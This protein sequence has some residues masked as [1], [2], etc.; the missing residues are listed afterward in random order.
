MSVFLEYA[1]EHMISA[2]KQTKDVFLLLFGYLHI[3][4]EI[5]LQ[6]QTCSA[7]LSSV[8]KKTQNTKT[9]NLKTRNPLIESEK[10]SFL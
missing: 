2:V 4:P 3:S 7:S 9:K 10:L 8:E 6:E 5:Q 1:G